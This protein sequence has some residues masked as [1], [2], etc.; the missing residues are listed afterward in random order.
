MEI[1]FG[2]EVAAEVSKGKLVGLDPINSKGRYV[3]KGRFGKSIKPILGVSELPILLN[4]SKL[5]YLIMKEA[6]EETHNDAKST[7]ARSRSKIWV[8][9]GMSLAKRVV[10][11]C[12]HCKLMKKKACEQKMGFLPEER[13]SFGTP[14]FTYISL[15]LAAP[16]LVLDMVK[17]RVT[18]KC[19]PVIFC[20]LNTGAVHIELLHSYG[21]DAFLSRWNVFVSLRGNPKLVVS[22]KGSQLVAA[23][24]TISKED[25]TSWDWDS[26]ANSTASTTEWKFVPAACQWQNGLAESRIKIFKQTFNRTVTSTLN[27][28]KSYL[29]YGDMQSLLATI[30]NKMN[31]RP[32]GL[33]SLTE[34]TI[35]P[36]T[37]NCLLLGRTSSAANSMEVQDVEENFPRRLRY[38]K[39]LFNVWWNEYEEQVFY[40]LL[41]YQKWKDVKRH[42]NLQVGDICILKYS[43]KIEDKFRYCKVIETH[44]DQEGNVRNV[45][46]SLRKRDSR[47]KLLPYKFKTPMKM[48]VGIQRLVLICPVEDIENNVK[49][50]D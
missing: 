36:L 37:P 47:E 34:D 12:Y 8:V 11:D 19:W 33:K 13:L 9:K 3:T 48:K 30:M 29:S 26:I 40:S 16:I 35:I 44:P 25:P 24:N 22:D 31:D 6:H 45:T 18:M 43:N 39:E 14:P 20:C 15:D 46:I 17:K 27:G 2:Q 42:I 32:I 21:A 28:N 7:L 50:Q 41:P 4:S 49:Q 1:T 38:C 5:A 10:K 23:A